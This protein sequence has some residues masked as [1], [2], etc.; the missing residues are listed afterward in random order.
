MKF[1]KDKIKE[2]FESH[3]ELA[4][5]YNINAK[6]ALNDIKTAKVLHDK[7]SLNNLK[8]VLTDT[9]KIVGQGSVIMF[10]FGTITLLAL[11]RMLKSKSAKQI[12]IQNILKLSIEATE[13]DIIK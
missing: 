4:I 8:D 1:S 6:I 3:R 11:K 9:L 2:Y 10:P 5:K 13:E 12:G 7:Q